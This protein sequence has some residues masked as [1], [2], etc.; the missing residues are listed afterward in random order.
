MK[1]FNKISG[2]FGLLNWV[3]VSGH[4]W[5]SFIRILGQVT[6]TQRGRR[7]AKSV[8]RWGGEG[9]GNC[10]ETSHPLSRVVESG[11]EGRDEKRRVSLN[12]LHQ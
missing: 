1:C 9:G 7:K 12:I 2:T 3:R 11:G 4:K 6:Q 10:G 5:V 8:Y